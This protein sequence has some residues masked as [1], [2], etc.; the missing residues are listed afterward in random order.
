MTA[1]DHEL[2]VGELI[3]CDWQATGASGIHAVPLV[4]D[5][6]PLTVTWRA[7]QSPTE[8]AIH[9]LCDFSVEGRALLIKERYELMQVDAEGTYRQRYRGAPNPR[10]CC[11][12]LV[13]WLRGG[14][15]VVLERIE[16]AAY[17]GLLRW[18]LHDS[19]QR[20]SADV[21]LEER[22]CRAIVNLRRRSILLFRWRYLEYR[23]DE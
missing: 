4:A 10:A 12:E 16:R 2:P 18:D 23:A 20:P 14:R 21:A 8:G 22:A 3:S 15:D 9:Y 5:G 13:E 19:Y 17:R 7:Y 11:T 1:M 6:P